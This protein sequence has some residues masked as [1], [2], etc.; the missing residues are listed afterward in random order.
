MPDLTDISVVANPNA[1]DNRA[2]TAPTS[3]FNPAATHRARGFHRTIPGY[4]PTTLITLDGLAAELG[5]ANVWIKDESTR[6]GLNAF[7]VLGASYAVAGLLAESRGMDPDELVFDQLVATG[8][9]SPDEGITICTATDGNHGRA[10]AW[11]AEQLGLGAVVYMP[12]GSSES[13]FN[14]IASHRADVSV[15]D[16]NYDETVAQAAEDAKKNGWLLVQDT[17]WS[18]YE[19]VPRRIMQGYLTI[20]DEA[21]EQ[22]RGEIPTHVFIQAGVGSL[23]ASIQAQF[24]ELLGATRPVTAV[25]EPAHAACCFASMAAGKRTP[26]SLDGDLPTIMAGLGCGTPSTVAWNILRDYSDVFVS[27]S[28]EIARIGM[29]ALARPHSGDPAI[30]SGESGAVTTGLLIGLLERDSQAVFADVIETMMLD[31]DARVL[32]IST[33]GA[34]DP[35]TYHKIVDR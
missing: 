26:L 21:L 7:K 3:D 28:D 31:V 22:L 34:T 23:A 19:S 24:F 11:T 2:T 29:R 33:E 9:P 14:A 5:V 16:G 4:E 6:F 20:L 12:R 18:G 13:R 25:V 35:D 8:A 30:V 32:L 17:A 15:V 27:C 1:R 10:V